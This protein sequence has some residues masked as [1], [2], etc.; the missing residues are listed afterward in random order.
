M[1]GC[2]DQ[3]AMTAKAAEPMKAVFGAKVEI[4]AG[5]RCAKIMILSSM[6]QQCWRVATLAVSNK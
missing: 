4:M 1:E 2:Y 6:G 3:T 5:R